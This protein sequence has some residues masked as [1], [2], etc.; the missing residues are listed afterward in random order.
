[1]L[2]GPHPEIDRRQAAQQRHPVMGTGRNPT[3]RSALRRGQALIIAL[4]LIFFLS[5]LVV[6]TQLQVVTQLGTSRTERG[7]ERALQMAE[8]GA[9]AYLNRLSQGNATVGV[10][11]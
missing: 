6:A 7:Y 8:A 11:A 9:N 3:R 5:I 1:M 4:A 10:P 2:A